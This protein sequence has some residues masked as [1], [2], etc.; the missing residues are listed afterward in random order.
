[1]GT[2]TVED[3]G[4]N[5]RHVLHPEIDRDPSIR[6]PSQGRTLY[7]PP[8]YMNESVFRSE[9]M[10]LTIRCPDVWVYDAGFE[11]IYDNEA[12][13]EDTEI[14]IPVFGAN[15]LVGGT[16]L[17]NPEVMHRE[18]GKLSISIEGT[19]TYISPR[20][21]APATDT[22]LP[23]PLKHEHIFFAGNMAIATYPPSSNIGTNPDRNRK[24]G[25]M[26][27]KGDA[28]GAIRRE[29]TFGGRI[30]SLSLRNPFKS[31]FERRNQNEG[32]EPF[33]GQNAQ[34]QA[35]VT[36]VQSSLTSWERPTSIQVS[37]AYPQEWISHGFS[38]PLPTE[39]LNNESRK[40]ST[41]SMTQKRLPPSFST[42]HLVEISG[43]RGRAYAENAEVSYRIIVEWN[44]L[45]HM[46]E[47]NRDSINENRHLNRIE[48]P[49]LY[50]PI[51][52]EIDLDIPLPD[53]RSIVT[54]RSMRSK[55][56]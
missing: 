20:L 40:S 26:Q 25:R 51:V 33:T 4:N 17:L 27:S 42:S 21:P 54:D 3:N 2:K 31:M 10:Q 19:F 12:E 1:M 15:D 8:V 41:T 46:Q 43:I 22:S 45:D 44:P 32:E 14:N 56:R 23:Q 9:N 34:F 37:E 52:D 29:L 11:D 18:K 7:E 36:R 6:L 53:G 47:P 30:K 28:T 38:F 16:V 48:A 55:K 35:E 39:P 49:F 5:G 24:F 13:L 50:E